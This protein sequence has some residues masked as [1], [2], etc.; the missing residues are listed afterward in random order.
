VLCATRSD[1]PAK[2]D[3]TLKKKKKKNERNLKSPDRHKHTADGRRESKGICPNL[4]FP[5]SLLFSWL[6][7]LLLFQVLLEDKKR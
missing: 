3:S 6:L 4:F 5:F 2:K 1:A 7:L